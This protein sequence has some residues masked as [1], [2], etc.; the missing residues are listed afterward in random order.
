MRPALSFPIR[1]NGVTIGHFTEDLSAHPT[2]MEGRVS[3]VGKWEPLESAETKAFLE[4]LAD[5]EKRPG[6]GYAIVD[7]PPPGWDLPLDPGH[8]VRPSEHGL[9]M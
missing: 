3:L 4:L 9:E 5:R 8:R 1:W 6:G 2:A 7:P